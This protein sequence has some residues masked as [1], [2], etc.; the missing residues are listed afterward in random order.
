MNRRF[1]KR[2]FLKLSAASLIAAGTGAIMYK[3]RINDLLKNSFK[4]NIDFLTM[5]NDLGAPENFYPL[6]VPEDKTI[7]PGDL[8]MYEGTASDRL[9]ITRYFPQ[10]DYG[11]DNRSKV[12]IINVFHDDFKQVA[13]KTGNIAQVHNSLFPMINRKNKFIIPWVPLFKKHTPVCELNSRLMD[14]V[15]KASIYVKDEGSSR[16]ALF[17]NKARKYEFAFPFYMQ[18]KAKKIITF[19]SLASNHCLYTSLTASCSRLGACFNRQNPEVLINLYPQKFHRLIIKKLKYLLALGARVRFLDN[20]IDVALK[21][22]SNRVREHYSPDDDLAYYE[23]GGSNPLTTLAHVNAVFELDEQ[24][25]TGTCPLKKPP[26]YIFVSLGSGGT[27]MGLV[28]GCFLLGWKTKVV[29]TTSQ[30][31]SMWKR[32]LIFGNPVQ[33]FLVQNAAKLLKKT[34]ELFCSLGLPGTV[35]TRLDP[36]TALENNFLYDNL[37]WEPA[38]GIPSEKTRAIIK[39]VHAENSLVLDQTFTGKSFTTM[40]NYAKKG[41]LN[42]KSVLF[43]NTHHRYDFIQNRKVKNTDLNLLPENLVNYLEKYNT[44]QAV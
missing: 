25:K 35:C 16:F 31:K 33:P 13:E 20:D 34:M 10:L 28:L 26:D 14:S 21:I 1:S 38:Y 29:G 40:F 44:C 15:T 7:G 37:T 42:K 19:G 3:G 32:A 27:C 12:Q 23:P 4:D 8:P 36:E 22:F 43:W 39:R 2:T 6:K 5:E 11:A 30:D 17:G 24:I 9:P 18:T 41:L